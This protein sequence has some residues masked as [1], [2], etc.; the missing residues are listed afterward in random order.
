[1]AHTH[2]VPAD[3]ESY[4]TNANGVE[5]DDIA[6]GT[7]TAWKNVMRS[8]GETHRY[9]HT[10]A[11]SAANTGNPTSLNATTGGAVGAVS[12]ATT[13]GSGNMPP[14]AVV[15]FIICTGKTN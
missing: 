11:S 14:Y 13:G 12:G 15:K 1:M 6:R 9:N 4:L 5:R 7:G 2:D 8:G 3:G 10:G